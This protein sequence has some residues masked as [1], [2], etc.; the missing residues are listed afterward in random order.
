[1]KNALQASERASGQTIYYRHML[2]QQQQALQNSRAIY[3]YASN[4]M[5]YETSADVSVGCTS[6]TFSTYQRRRG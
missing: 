3:D 4:R 5:I 1:M 2:N 6:A